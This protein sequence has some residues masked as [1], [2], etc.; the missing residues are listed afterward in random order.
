MDSVGA[1]GG[2]GADITF[3]GV[4]F[5]AG[6][7]KLFMDQLEVGLVFYYGSFQQTSNN[8]VNTYVD[9][10]K[11]TALAAFLNYL[12]GYN[13]NQGGFYF[14]AGAGLAYL[15]VNWEESSKTD[16][17]L[18][19]PLPGGGSKQTFAGSVG[20]ALVSLGPDTR[21]PVAWI[22]GLKSPSSSPSH[23]PV[24]PPRSSPCLRSPR[25]PFRPIGR[26]RRALTCPQFLY[27]KDQL[28]KGW[29]HPYLRC[30]RPMSQGTVQAPPP[31][32]AF[33]KLRLAPPRTPRGR[34]REVP[35]RPRFLEIRPN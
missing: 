15:G 27:H 33:R 35:G 21:L 16:P 17:T 2:I 25:I 8:G 13:R 32:V 10:T 11:I 12:Y 14:L 18:G 4:A 31:I 30:R 7:N 20:G 22:C 28:F 34:F 3:D 26:R 6:V 19:T 1:R 24:E 9:T 23:K 29:R 5:G